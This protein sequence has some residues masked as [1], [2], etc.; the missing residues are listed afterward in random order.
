M[1]EDRCQ[2][3][4]NGRQC[5]L[6]RHHAQSMNPTPHD[7]TTP[8]APKEEKFTK[9]EW[10]EAYQRATLLWHQIDAARSGEAQMDMIALA[11]LQFR[12][13]KPDADPKRQVIERPNRTAAGQ[14]YA[15][16]PGKD[17]TR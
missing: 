1:E 16:D 9:R 12:Q 13:E 11:L 6:A 14:C 4:V 5:R 7:F 2:T 10:D 17:V 3:W 8:D 15:V